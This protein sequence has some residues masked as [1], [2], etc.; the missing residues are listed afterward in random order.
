MNIEYRKLLAHESKIYRDIRLE[1]LEQFPDSFAASYQ[2][3]L[4]TEKLSME[5][6]IENQIPGKVAFGAFAD[7]R[8]IGI[9][10]FVKNENNSAS[11]YQMYVKKGFQGKNIGSGLVQAVIHEANEK[12][13]VNEIYLEVAANNHSAYQ[14]YKKN[15]FKDVSNENGLNDTSEIVMKYTI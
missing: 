3:S 6:N 5:I 14:L 1:S 4:K 8:L 7:Q 15:G 2:E 13:T 11:I 10:I 12:F 9:C